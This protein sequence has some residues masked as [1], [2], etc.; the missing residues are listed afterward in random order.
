MQPDYFSHNEP[1]LRI[2]FIWKFLG[3]IKTCTICS[4]HSKTLLLL[5][6]ILFKNSWIQ[7]FFSIKKN[8][9]KP[10]FDTSD[11]LNGIIDFGLLWVGG[12]S[13]CAV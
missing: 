12:L 8:L 4:V 9:T 5:K 13:Y 7:S 3:K 11:F 6:L 1:K 10:S 2:P